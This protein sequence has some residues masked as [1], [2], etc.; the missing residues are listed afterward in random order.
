M[1]KLSEK[2]QLNLK[3]LKECREQI[4]LSL[5]AVAKTVKT[6][7]AIESGNKRP[8]YKQLE[9]LGDLYCVPRWVFISDDLPDDYRYKQRPAF[10]KF[11][12]SEVF[13][14]VKV[15]RLVVRV[16]QLRDLF[17]E[18]QQDLGEQIESFK[19]PETRISS[20]SEV[21]ASRVRNWLAIPKEGFEFSQLK[22]VVEQKGIFIF[23]TSKHK[24]WSHIDKEFRGLTIVHDAMPIIIINN[25]DSKKVQSF[26]LMHELAHLLRE[27]IAIDGEHSTNP[28]EEWCNKFAG[29]VLMPAS[30]AIWNEYENSLDSLDQVKRLAKQF[31]VS[32]YACL[33]RLRQLKRI[34]GQLYQR[35]EQELTQAYAEQREK[36]KDSKGG[37]SRNRSKEVQEQF[38]NSFVR[39]ALSS[40]HNEDMTLYKVMKLFGL[41]RAQQV[42]DLERLV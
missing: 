3:T 27:D 25:S 29:E 1:G 18:L 26:T 19:F 20:N 35:H 32:P 33:V 10:R 36:L 14:D 30:S 4:G 15:R 7:E 6:I 41:R 38:G 13:N 2:F 16:E 11:K 42:F 37:L 28:D 31:N 34:S 9:I 17:I 21:A 40:W 22:D 39:T 23:L 24:G 5:E 8:T 12:G